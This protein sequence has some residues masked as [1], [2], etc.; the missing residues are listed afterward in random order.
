MYV[1]ERTIAGH[2]QRITTLAWQNALKYSVTLVCCVSHWCFLLFEWIIKII[3]KWC[4][5]GWSIKYIDPIT[6][7]AWKMWRASIDN[8]MNRYKRWIN[9]LKIYLE[10]RFYLKNRF[11]VLNILCSR[12][13]DMQKREKF[14]FINN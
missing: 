1:D 9:W 11:N 4:L 10:T 2:S 14:A 12:G 8:I 13:K 7:G 5:Y 6:G 3:I